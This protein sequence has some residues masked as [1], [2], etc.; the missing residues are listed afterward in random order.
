MKF[1]VMKNSFYEKSILESYRP[2]ELYKKIA[3][4]FVTK[5]GKSNRKWNSK[6]GKKSNVLLLSVE[7][8]IC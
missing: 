7:Q 8:K 5:G 2:N 1:P 3:C 4:I 6:R